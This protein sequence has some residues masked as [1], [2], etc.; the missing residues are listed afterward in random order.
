[1]RLR[2]N[3][4]STQGGRQLK[5]IKMDLNFKLTRKHKHVNFLY[6]QLSQTGNRA[7]KNEYQFD[8]CGDPCSSASFLS[9]SHT[10]SSVIFSG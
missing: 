6:T 9:C 7:E 8:P 3:F 10:S 1:M 4:M 2:R 5:I